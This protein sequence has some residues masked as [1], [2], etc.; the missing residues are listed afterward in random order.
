MNAHND[1][2]LD[3]LLQPPHVDDDGFADAVVARVDVNGA[4]KGRGVVV[5]FTAVGVVVGAALV[6]DLLHQHPVTAIAA[7]G[8]TAKLL[9]CCAAVFAVV[10]AALSGESL[11][12]HNL[13]QLVADGPSTLA[14][15]EHPDGYAGSAAAVPTINAALKKPQELIERT[16][17][18]DDDT[19]LEVVR[20]A[21]K[22][23]SLFG[24]VWFFFLA[25]PFLFI[26]GDNVGII[27]GQW[28]IMDVI[29]AMVFGGFFL[30]TPI[31][32]LT[33]RQAFFKECEQL[34]ITR[35]LARRLRWRLTLANL[36][37][38]PGPE[39]D[40]RAVRRLR[41]LPPKKA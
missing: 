21:R 38:S 20:A 26:A 33:S 28:M 10:A 31:V 6:L 5:A 32:W 15:P 12:L 35:P 18:L 23:R 27:D 22:H 9:A 24:T 7:S 37:Y 40:D 3:E 14:L 2:W 13:R 41:Q 30:G 1:Q 16:E 34:G 11:K 39:A 4:G 17:D 8:L 29:V 36:T 25:A 19:A